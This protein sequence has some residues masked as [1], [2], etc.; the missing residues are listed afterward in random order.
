MWNVK[1]KTNEQNKTKADI[2]PGNKIVIRVWGVRGA[3]K[4]GEGDS[5]VKTFIYKMWQNIT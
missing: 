2:G 5:E 3:D 1:F 4:I